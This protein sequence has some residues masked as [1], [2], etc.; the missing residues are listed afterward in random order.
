MIQKLDEL[1]SHLVVGHEGLHDGGHLV[2]V[3]RVRKRGLHHLVHEGMSVRELDAV[4]THGQD[5]GPEVEV[6][7]LLHEVTRKNLGLEVQ[8]VAAP[9]LL[10]E[11][12]NGASDTNGVEEGAN[13]VFVAVEVEELADD[14]QG[15]FLAGDMGA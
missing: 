8:A 14:Q 9:H 15:V 5:L 4:L 11:T 6:L 7:V 3:L 12:I 1:F 2:G 10:H 13:D